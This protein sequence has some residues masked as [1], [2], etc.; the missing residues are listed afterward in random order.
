[1]SPPPAFLIEIDAPPHGQSGSDQIFIESGDIS[2][3]SM[4][5]IDP[6]VNNFILNMQGFEYHTGLTV[7]GQGV[8]INGSTPSN[9]AGI[10]LGKTTSTSASAGTNGDVPAQVAQYLTVNILGTNYKIPLYLA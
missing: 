9:A 8:A 4:I 3:F 5:S 6:S 7:G 10:G 1:L 2:G